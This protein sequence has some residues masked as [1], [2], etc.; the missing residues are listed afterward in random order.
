MSDKKKYYQ[1]YPNFI[2]FPILC[3]IAFDYLIIEIK[4]YA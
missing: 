1:Q 3:E 4:T 2:F